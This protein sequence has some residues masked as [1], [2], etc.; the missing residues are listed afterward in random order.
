MTGK[1]CT[2]CRYTKGIG[3]DFWC[4]EGH[5]EYEVFAGETNCPYYEYF[6]W[7]KGVPSES[8]KRF[9][10]EYI[11]YEPYY[12]DKEQEYVDVDEAELKFNDLMTMSDKQV[13]KCLNKL[14]EDNQDLLT[15]KEDAEYE[16]LHLKEK[17]EEVLE[18]NRLLTHKLQKGEEKYRDYDKDRFFIDDGYIRDILGF[19][20][21]IKFISLHQGI[22]IR[23]LLN[24]NWEQ[25]NEQKCR[26]QRLKGENKNLHRINGELHRRVHK[27]G[28]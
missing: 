17:Y 15:K 25:F 10:V 22:S 18:K 21:P 4:G 27:L 9:T 26:I 28:Q 7:S 8:E 2:D 6:D 5:T 3:F 19:I 11:E 23:N 12:I 24:K 14:Y 16:L 13:V 20:E 1:R